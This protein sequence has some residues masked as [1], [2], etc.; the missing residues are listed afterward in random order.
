MSKPNGILAMDPSNY[1]EI[2]GVV[3]DLDSYA[4][5]CAPAEQAPPAPK[6]P[7]PAAPIPAPEGI[8]AMDPEH[9]RVLDGVAMDEDSF[10]RHSQPPTDESPAEQTVAVG[11]T[12]PTGVFVVDPFPNGW[13]PAEDGK[14]PVPV[15]GGALPPVEILENGTHVVTVIRTV[16]LH[17]GSGSGSGSYMTSYTTSYRTS[18]LS[19]G[20]GSYV[21][22]SCTY[23]VGGYG[24][25]LI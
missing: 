19:S 14:P 3:F 5:H 25:E 10:Q 9:H 16:F 12:A 23:L 4:K 24:L 20:S 11:E 22:G 18:Y 21:F 8:L 13:Y 15:M 17:T 1:R 7:A 2:D 6:E